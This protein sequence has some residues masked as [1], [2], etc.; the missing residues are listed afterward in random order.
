MT[1][2][3][4]HIDHVIEAMSNFLKHWA[5]PGKGLDNADKNGVAHYFSKRQ[6]GLMMFVF[7]TQDDLSVELEFDCARLRR[8]GRAYMETLAEIIITQLEAA[9]E[10]K[11]QRDTLIVLPTKKIQPATPISSAVQRAIVESVH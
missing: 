6:A 11:Q 3:S 9:R 10:E 1:E 7:V 8:E 4:Y 2:R 5:V